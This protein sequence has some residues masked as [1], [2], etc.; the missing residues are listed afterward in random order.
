[1]KILVTGANG[2]IGRHL[3]SHLVAQGHTVTAAVRRRGAAPADTSEV[4]IADLG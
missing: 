2:F 4:L 1:M 3:C